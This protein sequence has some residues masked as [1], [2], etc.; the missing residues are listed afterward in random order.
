MMIVPDLVF[1]EM[2]FLQ[3]QPAADA[4]GQDDAISADTPGQSELEQE[5]P[6]SLAVERLPPEVFLV[7]TPPALYMQPRIDS[8]QRSEQDPDHFGRRRGSEQMLPPSFGKLTRSATTV[9]MISASLPSLPSFLLKTSNDPSSSDRHARRSTR[10]RAY[11]YRKI[12]QPY[13]PRPDGRPLPI[14]DAALSSMRSSLRTRPMNA[15]LHTHLQ[16][17]QSAIALSDED[18]AL[19]H[20]VEMSQDSTR[21]YTSDILRIKHPDGHTLQRQNMHE[22]SNKSTIDDYRAQSRAALQATGV[23]DAHASSRPTE[24]HEGRSQFNGFSNSARQHDGTTIM[25]LLPNRSLKHLRPDTHFDSRAVLAEPQASTSNVMLWVTRSPSRQDIAATS[26]SRPSIWVDDRTSAAAQ[27][28]DQ[29][30][31]LEV[32]TTTPMTRHTIVTSTQAY[33][34]ECRPLSLNALCRLNSSDPTQD[35]QSYKDPSSGHRPFSRANKL[36]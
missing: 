33:E 26:L 36:Y 22:P 30:C 27:S 10:D 13:T 8:Q 9:D 6:R 2:E 24:Q 32:H 29:R 28:S 23:H 19:L 31:Q 34:E 16:H 5:K 11:D 35:V 21:Y 15:E 17:N 12:P 7:P 1:N 14:T 25:N 20:S 18:S 3:Q 4:R